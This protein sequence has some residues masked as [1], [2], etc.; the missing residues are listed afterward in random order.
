MEMVDLADSDEADLAVVARVV[1]RAGPATADLA[2]PGTEVR[3]VVGEADFAAMVRVAVRAGAE[4]ADLA[5]V[6]G[7]GTAVR[8]GA[9]KADLAVVAGQ[10]TAVRAGV[11]E[12]DLAAMVRAAVRAGADLEGMVGSEAKDWAEE[13]WAVQDSGA[14][15]AERAAQVAGSVAAVPA[16]PP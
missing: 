4:K 11:D 12:A 8:A 14:V 15:V 7:Q 16:P 13:G 1:V 2:G 10:G 5:V 6:A 3:A 9:E